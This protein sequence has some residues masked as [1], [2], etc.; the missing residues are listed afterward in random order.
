MWF[1]APGKLAVSGTFGNV[2]VPPHLLG[3]ALLGRPISPE[4]GPT[5]VQGT[6]RGDPQFGLAGPRRQNFA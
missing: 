1:P 4:S 3:Q 6:V 2:G 5:F